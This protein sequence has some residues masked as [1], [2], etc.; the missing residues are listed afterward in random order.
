MLAPI[1]ALAAIPD[2]L[3][4]V[5]A[6]PLLCAGITTYARPDLVLL[7]VNLPRKDGF[8]VLSEIQASDTLRSIPVIVFTSSALTKEKRKALALGAHDF[9]TKPGSLAGLID[10]LRSVCS[11]FLAAPNAQL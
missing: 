6:A 9:I 10:T 7:N 2:G 5:D 8:E 11:Q 4:D 1:E 3:N